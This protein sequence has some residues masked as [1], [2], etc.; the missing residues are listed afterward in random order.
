[1]ATSNQGE[2]VFGYDIRPGRNRSGSDIG[3]NLCVIA[4]DIDANG[5]DSIAISTGDTNRIRG[6]TMEAIPNGANGNIAKS[7]K[8][9]VVASG[10]IAADARIAPD[11]DGKVKAAVSGDRSFGRALETAADDGDIILAEINCVDPDLIA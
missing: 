2:V 6:V 11:A 9:H 1:M 5:P 10:A 4:N 8:K 7:G 3:K